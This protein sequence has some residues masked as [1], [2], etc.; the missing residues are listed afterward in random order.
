MTRAISVLIGVVLLLGVGWYVGHRPSS[1]LSR[2]LATLQEDCT[3][4]TT[5]LEARAQT[6]EARGRLWQAR[7]ELVLASHD[8]DQRNF[9]TANERATRAHDLITEA[10]ADPGITMDLK[11][12]QDMVNS[13]VGKVGALDPE[14]ADVLARAASELG[15]LLERTGQA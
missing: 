4:R 15:R 12:V 7:A 3:H 2:Q 11:P 14:A 13:A 1:G 6:A 10:A 9:G 5:E 8:V